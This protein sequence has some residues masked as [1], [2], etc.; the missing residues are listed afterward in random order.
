MCD[1]IVVVAG[2]ETWL[3]KNSDREPGEAQAVS[4]VPGAP[5]PSSRHAR[6]RCTHVSVADRG[7]R[8]AV[9]LSRPSWM[10]GAEMGVNESGLAVANEAVFTRMPVAQ[11]GL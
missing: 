3:A 6:R 1:S 10:W 2:G 7:R 5:A 11:Q 4:W 9:V 8:R